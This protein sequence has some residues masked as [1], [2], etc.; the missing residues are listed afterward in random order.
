LVSNARAA[1]R[2]VRSTEN[3]NIG[4]AAGLNLNGFSEAS[5]LDNTSGFLALDSAYRGER[6]QFRLNASFDTQ[7]TLT[8]EEATSGLTQINKQRYQFVV[9]PSWTYQISE[10]A[11]FD[12]GLSYTDVIYE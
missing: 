5:D 8:S 9:R 4:L 11:S 2:A 3:S 12:L 6:N 1:V 10:R 7:S